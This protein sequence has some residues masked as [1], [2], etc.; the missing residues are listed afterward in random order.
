MDVA[1]AILQQIIDWLQKAPA[2]TRLFVD[3]GDPDEVRWCCGAMLL[4]SENA[5]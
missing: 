5:E 4:P 3:E 1:C 2:Q